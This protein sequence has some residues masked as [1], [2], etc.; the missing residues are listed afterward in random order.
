MHWFSAKRTIKL[1]VKSLWMHRLRSTLTM[2]GIVFGVCSVIAMLAI[3]EGASREAQDAIAR[4][5]STNLIIETVKPSDE[6]A[7]SGEA[8]TMRKYGLTYVDAE[9]IRNTIPSVQVIVP[10]REIDQEARYLNRKVAIK[11]IGTIPWYTEVSPVRLIRGRF[12][13]SVDLQYQLATCVIENQVAR[14]LF[15]FDDP[16]G[17]DVRIYGN[18]YRVVGIVARLAGGQTADSFA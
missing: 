16:L 1:G 15:A 5:G 6:Q 2:L 3:G 4:L 18:Y 10:V 12:L 9:S 14:K 8:N 11:L 17:M 13:S 7:N